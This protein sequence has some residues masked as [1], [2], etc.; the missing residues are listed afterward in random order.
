MFTLLDHG[1]GIT[2]LCLAVIAFMSENVTAVMATM[3]AVVVMGSNYTAILK[4]FG[5]CGVPILTGP[6]GSCKSEA[7]KYALSPF[8]A[9]ESHTCNNQTTPSYL[10]KAASKTTIPIY[11][12]D[13]SEKSA[14]AWEELFIDAYN[15]SGR[16]TRLHGIETFQTLPIVSA[17]W[18]IETDNECTLILST[19]PFNTTKMSLVP[20]CFLQTWLISE[21]MLLNQLG[22]SSN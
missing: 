8:G 3:S 2:D 12:N 22:S 4:M 13:V 5:C 19:S 7:T 11:V 21:Q 9:H 16:G 6:P 10:F 18:C 17:N 1:Q 15:G 14:D 20:I